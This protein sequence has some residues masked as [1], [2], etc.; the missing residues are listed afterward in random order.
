MK[1]IIIT[2]GNNQLGLGHVYQSLTLANALRERQRELLNIHFMTRSDHNICELIRSSGYDVEY[3]KNDSHIFDKLKIHNPDRIIF[4][5]LNVSPLLAEKIKKV[6]DTKLIIFTNLTE[7]NNYAD[8]VVF[9]GFERN[10]QNVVNRDKILST[11]QFFGL[12]F[13]IL[14]PEFY[15]FKKKKKLYPKNIKKIMLIFGASDPSNMTTHVLQ[16]LLQMNFDFNISAVIGSVFRHELELNEML[17]QYKTSKSELKILKNITNV[18]ELMHNSDLVITSPGLSFSE[19]LVVGTPV[20]GFHQNEFQRQE[21]SDVFNT[22]GIDDLHKL[23]LII[24]NKNFI[25]P[26]APFIQAM[27]IGEGK[28]EIIREILH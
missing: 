9:A 24:K 19:A 18:A 22:L 23:S 14:R 17:N 2:D 27:H 25:F 3:F 12:K 10:L 7:A 15:F 16:K 11:K 8:V 20:L 5:Q 1:I 28:E 6:L 26:N 21:Y 4:D 13:W